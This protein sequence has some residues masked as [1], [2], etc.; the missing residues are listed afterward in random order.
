MNQLSK[1]KAVRSVVI[2]DSVATRRM[3]I[4]ILKDAPVDIVAEAGDS[5]TAVKACQKERPELVFL[6]VVMPGG[7]GVE[8]LRQVKELFPETTVL[9]V[10]S[11]NGRDIIMECRKLGASGYILKP[12]NREKVL[13]S[14]HKLCNEIQNTRQESAKEINP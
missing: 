2:D 9:M 12:F 3:L 4:N 6:D 11:I 7:S 10:T 13:A 1:A 14:V 5:V 8:V